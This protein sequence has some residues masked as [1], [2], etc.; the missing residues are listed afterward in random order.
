MK[1]NFRELGPLLPLDTPLKVQIDPSNICNFKCLF[2]PTGD[3]QLLSNVTYRENKIM[4]LKRYKFV[5]DGLKDFPQKIK[6]L[7][8][9]KDGEPLIN[10]NLHKMIEYAKKLDIA[11]KINLITNG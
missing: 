7:R 3:D 9:A 1:N 2:C 4:S 8:F 6:V 5:L 10:K 11:D